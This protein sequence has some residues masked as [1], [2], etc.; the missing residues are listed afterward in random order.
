MSVGNPHGLSESDD[1]AAVQHRDPDEVDN[2]SACP[3]SCARLDMN[4]L[5]FAEAGCLHAG[6]SRQGGASRMP[7]V[8]PVRLDSLWLRPLPWDLQFGL[9]DAASFVWWVKWRQHG[10]GNGCPR[11]VLVNNEVSPYPGWER[12][13]PMLR[14]RRERPCGRAGRAASRLISAVLC[15][16][17]VALTL[18]GCGQEPA[19]VEQGP[20][21]V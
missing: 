2:D 1:V 7:P 4:G 16:F 17:A 11:Q 20:R 21:I 12:N 6:S 14:T 9:L 5:T 18:L 13:R 10:A 8:R 15:S 19:V 3:Q